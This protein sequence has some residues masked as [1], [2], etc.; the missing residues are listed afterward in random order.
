MNRPLTRAEKNRVLLD[1]D[2]AIHY[3]AESLGKPWVRFEKRLRVAELTATQAVRYAVHVRRKRWRKF[4]NK[5]KRS[6]AALADYRNAFPGSIPKSDQEIFKEQLQSWRRQTPSA[7]VRPLR[8][9]DQGRVECVERDFQY[10]ASL[11]T[12]RYS[13]GPYC[14]F[15]ASLATSS[16]ADHYRLKVN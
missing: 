12:R 15:L 1:P 7:S 13:L 5:I 8:R 10:E 11:A 14:R 2:L 6:V 3:T 4:K 9:S 16:M